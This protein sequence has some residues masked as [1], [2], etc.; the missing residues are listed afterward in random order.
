VVAIT[1]AGAEPFGNGPSGH[2]ELRFHAQ[3]NAFHMA[4]RA[5]V[6]RGDLVFAAHGVHRRD[7]G[8]RGQIARGRKSG[9]AFIFRIGIAA[10]DAKHRRRGNP[11]AVI[12][13]L[14]RKADETIFKLARDVELDLATVENGK[15]RIAWAF[16]G[17]IEAANVKAQVVAEPATV[18]EI[19]ACQAIVQPGR[20][21]D[22]TARRLAGLGNQV[23]HAARRIGRERGCRAATD[24]FDL[25]DIEIGAHEIR[26]RAALDVAKLH[27]R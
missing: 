11:R 17:A 13:D 1:S 2:F 8:R 15:A 25:R 10:G 19:T 6:D 22:R 7:V 5:Q 26:G 4:A 18:I 3:G 27:H 21:H 24:G 16:A 20:S 12:E 14:G 9:Q 23:D